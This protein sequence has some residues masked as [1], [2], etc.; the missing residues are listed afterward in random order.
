M[1]L[2]YALVLSL[3]LTCVLPAQN[4][5]PAAPDDGLQQALTDFIRAFDNLDWDRFRASFADDATVFYP[6]SFPERA[7]GRAEYEKTFKVFFERI[8]DGKSSPPYMD[9]QPKELKIQRL[10]DVAI[11][12]FQLEDRPGMLNRRTLVWQ[13]TASGWKIVHL[14]ASEV[15]VAAGP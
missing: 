1:K 8:R 2:V 13:R 5:P 9:I 7:D 10:N 15:T 3:L 11:V 6:R 14:H 4:L 12:T